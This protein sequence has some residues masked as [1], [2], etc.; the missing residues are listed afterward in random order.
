MLQCV[1]IH[2]IVF[3]AIHNTSYPLHRLN[4]CV[5]KLDSLNTQNYVG[6]LYIKLLMIERKKRVGWI[7]QGMSSFCSRKLLCIY[8]FVSSLC[9]DAQNARKWIPSWIDV[10]C[11]RSPSFTISTHMLKI[12]IKTESQ[13]TSRL[14]Y[15]CVNGHKNAR[16]TLNWKH[17]RPS[18]KRTT[19]TNNN[20]CKC[21]KPKRKKIV[22]LTR[23][24][25]MFV[26]IFIK[27]SICVHG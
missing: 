14:L 13:Q 12:T 18:V 16:F 10:N 2:N 3:R 22:L 15:F 19:P 25:L 9:H 11:T 17:R 1:C 23:S 7:P 4:I 8:I 20:N 5:A 21:N 27:C 26:V 6:L 24:Y